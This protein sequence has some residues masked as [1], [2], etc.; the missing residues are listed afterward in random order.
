MYRRFF[1]ILLSSLILAA[2]CGSTTGS[3]VVGVTSQ[4]PDLDTLDVVLQVDGEVLS[5]QQLVVGPGG[6]TSFPAELAFDDV[7]DGS[8]VAVTLRGFDDAGTLRVERQLE[9]TV[10]GGEKR[11]VRV[12]LEA[13]CRLEA[14]GGPPS[15]PICDNP[16]STCIAGAC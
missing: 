2:A 6:T 3:L 13:A 15:A 11:L 14:P 1:A 4:L 16:T 7:D 12:V 10:V 5:E 8:T 9:T